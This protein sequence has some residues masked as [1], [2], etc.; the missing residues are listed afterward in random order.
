ME[1]PKDGMLATCNDFEGKV[2]VDGNRK[3]IDGS[4]IVSISALKPKGEQATLKYSARNY[5]GLTM[6]L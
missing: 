2:N 4:I 5:Y 1:Y 3:D 6:S